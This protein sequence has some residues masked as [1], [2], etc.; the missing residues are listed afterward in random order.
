MVLKK[1]LKIPIVLLAQI[2]R[3]ADNRSSSKPAL[4]DLKS[5]GS[6]EEDSDI[7][8]IGHRPYPYTKKDEDKD[9]AFWE[10]AKHR[11]G[12]TWNIEMKWDAKTTTFYEMGG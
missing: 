12:L 9:I 4:S 10:I 5:T 1:E 2:N 7:V 11:G 8:L 3:N 6:L